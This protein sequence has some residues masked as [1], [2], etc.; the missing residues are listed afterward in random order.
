MAS[1]LPSGSAMALVHKSTAGRASV[2]GVD[3]LRRTGGDRLGMADRF[4]GRRDAEADLL[5]LGAK[6]AASEGGNAAALDPGNGGLDDRAFAVAVALL[7]GDA[8]VGCNLSGMAL[9]LGAA[10]RVYRVGGWRC[11]GGGTT[12]FGGERGGLAARIAVVTGYP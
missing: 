2:F 8:A 6:G 7:P 11:L 4:V 9:S 1:A 12:I 5:G 3:A 10:V